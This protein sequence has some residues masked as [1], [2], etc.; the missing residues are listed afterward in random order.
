MS[1]NDS[2]LG[3]VFFSKYKLEKK[4]GEGSFGAIYLSTYE[5]V[6]YALKFENRTN[7]QSLLKAEAYIMSYLKGRKFLLL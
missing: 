2:L 4:L 1:K 7:G 6:K 3:K 5:G